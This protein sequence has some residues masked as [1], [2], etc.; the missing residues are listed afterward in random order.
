MSNPSDLA[1]AYRLAP[2]MNR[3]ILSAS[4]AS[5][6]I[7][8]HV[9]QSSPPMPLSAVGGGG[10]CQGYGPLSYRG[11]YLTPT[12]DGSQLGSRPWRNRGVPPRQARKLAL[13]FPPARTR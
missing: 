10:S 2:S 7:K 11:P 3:A 13:R 5:L 8:C 4:M 12:T 1:V 6:V 9:D